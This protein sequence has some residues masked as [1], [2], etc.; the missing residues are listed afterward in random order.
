[1]F[2][3]SRDA[4][5]SKAHIQKETFDI[6]FLDPPYREGILIPAIKA[7]LPLMSEFSTIVCEHPTDVELPEEIG[8]F[9]T[10]RSYRYGKI[11]VTVYKSNKAVAE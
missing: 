7:I 8:G 2:F 1:M 10:V 3:R 9:T 5:A 11:A 6:A 4:H